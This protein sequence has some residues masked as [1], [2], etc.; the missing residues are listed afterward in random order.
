MSNFNQGGDYH[1]IPNYQN[2]PT[3]QYPPNPPQYPS[4]NQD[5][6]NDLPTEQLIYSQNQSENNN[7]N[8]TPKKPEVHGRV[9]D[10]NAPPVSNP[11]MTMNAQPMTQPQ[12]LPLYQV[13]GQN[14]PFTIPIIKSDPN[15]VHAQMNS[16]YIRQKL[17]SIII[18]SIVFIAIVIILIV[19]FAGR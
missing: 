2:Y 13:G 5:N 6:E 9:S 1:N 8:Y 14:A 19:R 10:A 16:I 15:Y 18:I 17:I 7:Q 3:E 12:E 4:L 11:N